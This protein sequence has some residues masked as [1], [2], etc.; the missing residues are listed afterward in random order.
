MFSRQPIIGS[1][2][3]VTPID[4]TRLNNLL[5]ESHYDSNLTG[6][7]MQGFWDGFDIGYR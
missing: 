2:K 1:M 7:L 5:R 6:H 3:I 4:V